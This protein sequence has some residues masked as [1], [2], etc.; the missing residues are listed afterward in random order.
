MASFN[1]VFVGSQPLQVQGI[2]DAPSI[3]IDIDPG[4]KAR[5]WMDDVYAR[6]SALSQ[7][8]IDEI[9]AAMNRSV[10]AP[11]MLRIA[12]EECETA[13][14]GAGPLLAAHRIAP[15]DAMSGII[16]LITID[17]DPNMKAEGDDSPRPWKESPGSKG[18]TGRELVID[19][20]GMVH[21]GYTQWVFG[22]PTGRFVPGRPWMTRAAERIAA[23]VPSVIEAFVARMVSYAVGDGDMVEVGVSDEDGGELDASGAYYVEWTP[24]G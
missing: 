18:P 9:L 8:S 10:V 23:E 3:T 7:E 21:N 15:Q 17:I 1:R 19:Y 2:G 5:K 13:I 6:M 20:A 14:P 11:L 22:H 24:N 4:A 16:G 12:R